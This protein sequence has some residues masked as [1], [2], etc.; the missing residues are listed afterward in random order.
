MTVESKDYLRFAQVITGVG[1]GMIGEHVL[2]V[3][4]VFR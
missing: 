1:V 3:K 2:D 4:D